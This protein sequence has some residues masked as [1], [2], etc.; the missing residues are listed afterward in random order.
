[1][2]ERFVSKQNPVKRYFSVPLP[3]VEQEEESLGFHLQ[4]GEAKYKFV[5]GGERRT[6]QNMP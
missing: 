5:F 6:F 2:I 1:V 4:I 3:N